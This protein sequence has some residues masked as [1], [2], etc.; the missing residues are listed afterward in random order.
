MDL[1]ARVTSLDV[2]LAL[3]GPAVDGGT[4]QSRLES[5]GK[6]SGAASLLTHLLELESSGHVNVRRVGGY[7]FSLTPLGSAAVSDLAPGQVVEHTLVMIDLV[8][9]VPFTAAKGDEAARDAAQLL[10][11]VA[12][13]T[14]RRAGGRTVKAIGDG[15]LGCAPLDVEVLPALQRV[16]GVVAQPESGGWK[17][18]ASIHR[19]APIEI[20]GD[21]FGHDVNLVA[22]LCALAAPG[23][24]VCS[25]PGAP[26][27]ELVEVR[28][29]E[30]R[31]PIVRR[32]L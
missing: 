13:T 15:V 3:V 21:L 7:L 11:S 30:D 14:L 18:R 29:L 25:A 8:G 31:V 2:L 22:R 32:S 20:R 17:L 4:V 10:H 12:D 6:P 9:F 23:E 1:V 24:V 28:G 27:A 5:L 16:A 19:G 26:G